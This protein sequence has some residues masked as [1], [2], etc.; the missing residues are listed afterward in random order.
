MARVKPKIYS[1]AIEVTAHC[2]Q[3]CSYCY[4]AWRAD[5]GAGMEAGSQK[6]L[7]ARVR[8]LL[9]AIDVDHVTITG[10]EPF[11]RRD[12]FDLLD[13]IHSEGV[14]I[15]IIS[16]GGLIDDDIATRLS[17]YPVGY[18]QVTL[19]GPT[20]ALHDA[21]V[22]GVGHFDATLAGISA[23]RRAGVSVVGCIVVTRKNAAHVAEILTLFSS[24][25]VRYIALSR[26]S[27]AGYA[28]RHVAELLP[29][30]DDLLVAFRQA[31]PF[32]TEE[33]PERKMR[34]VCTMPVPPCA[35]EVEELAPLEF[36]TC[37]IGTDKQEF[38]LGPDGRLRHCTLHRSGLGGGG[39]EGRDIL[40]DEVDPA[41]IVTGVEVREYKAVRPEFCAGC[42]HEH[43]CGGGCGAASEWVLGSRSLPDPFVWQ[44]IDDELGERLENERARRGEA[45][46]RLEV[47]A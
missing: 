27:P 30:R 17:R 37:A 22:G 19:D 16:N 35:V 29:S 15:Q 32:V 36:G 9:D 24:L 3:K 10:G 4:N 25:G 2:Q 20:A 23:L 46:R 13:V 38:A 18:V 7:H 45:K 14:G 12:V 39:S 41:A 31:I 40:D 26:F 43:T 5:N 47:I 44:H 42:V 21:H 34:I 33:D 11:A 6:R 8:K 1:V 28:S